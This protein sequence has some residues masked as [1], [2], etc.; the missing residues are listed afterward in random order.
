MGRIFSIGGQL[1]DWDLRSADS[2]YHRSLIYMA[3]MSFL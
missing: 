3:D 1:K 2:R